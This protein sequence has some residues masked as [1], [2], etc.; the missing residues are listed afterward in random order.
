MH[1][2]TRELYIQHLAELANTYGVADTGKMFDISTPIETKIRAAIQESVEFLNLITMRTSKYPK[3]QALRVGDSGGGA[4][5]TN[6]SNGPRKGRKLGAPTGT[7]WE[8][9]LTEFDVSIDYETLDTWA[10]EPEFYRLL[11]QA[12]WQGIG[13]DKMTIGFYGTSVAEETDL[14]TNPLMEDVNIGWVKK[15]IDGNPTNYM[16]QSG[17]TANEISIGAA[18][19][20]KNLDQLVADVYNGIPVHRRTGREVAI[21]GQE[22]V[23]DDISKVLAAHGQ[24]PSEKTVPLVRLATAYGTLPAMVVPKF[25]DR[26][27]M[28]TDPKNLQIISQT[29]GMRRREVEQPEYNCITTF[30]SDNDAYAIGDL[31]GIA[32]INAD[33][34]VF[35]ES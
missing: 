13:L 26:G 8:T 24:T 10:S 31:Q 16:N 35:K 9:A 4:K 17:S 20:Y 5:R 12:V 30:I 14:D 19:T 34:V 3:G 1:N 25:P 28:V 27:V 22:L 18:G 21:I 2:D 32:A 23:S 6:V 11:M 7:K 33:N 29:A 15:L